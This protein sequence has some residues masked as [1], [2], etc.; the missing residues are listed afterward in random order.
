MWFLLSRRLRSWL[1]LA[2]AVP[3]GGRLLEAIGVRVHDRNPRVGSALTSTG[4][5]LRNR[6]R[7]RRR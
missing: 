1:L 7:R 4:S 3:L 5:T 6:G 2:V